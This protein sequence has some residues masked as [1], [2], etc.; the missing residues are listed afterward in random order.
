MQ[1]EI[2]I[3]KLQPR[4][5]PRCGCIFLKYA[6]HNE[7]Y[8][9]RA[10]ARAPKPLVPHDHNPELLIVPL[11][12]GLV[13]IIDRSDSDLVSPFNWYPSN[14]RNGCH[15]AMRSARVGEDKSV[16]LHRAIMGDIPDGMV[17]DHID[18]D[19]L[20]NTRCNLRVVTMAQNQWNRVRSK[21]SH[22]G[23]FWCNT[24]MKWLARIRAN[25]KITHIGYFDDIGDAIQARAKFVESIHGEFARDAG[26]V[27]A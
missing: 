16:M 17:V 9:S 18:G 23:V 8:C 26:D 12:K 13:S 27:A 14:G 20:N 11:T 4:T 3:P 25:G 5:C 24:K 1:D 6:N 22:P 2:T 19:G 10:C 7:T 21:S 15:Y